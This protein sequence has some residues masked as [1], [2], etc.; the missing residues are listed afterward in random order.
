M[1][2]TPQ[3]AG[4]KS[5]AAAAKRFGA[6]TTP[7]SGNGAAKNDFLTSS[8]ES[9]PISVEWK[10]TG[11]IQYALKRREIEAAIQNALIDART[12]LFGIEYTSPRAGVKPLRVVIMEEGDYLALH[13]RVAE[14]QAE[15][16]GFHCGE[17]CTGNDCTFCARYK[18]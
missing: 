1:S 10:S 13:R 6:K 15:V 9:D 11:S 16:E 14:L 7:G 2:S 3:Q 17:G 18:S 8:Q 4:R 12:S 5:E